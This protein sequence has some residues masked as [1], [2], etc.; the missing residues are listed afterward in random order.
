MV[1]STAVL[2]LAAAGLGRGLATSTPTSAPDNGDLPSSG[3]SYS[4]PGGLQLVIESASQFPLFSSAASQPETAAAGDVDA[5]TPDAADSAAGSPPDEA[6]GA[7][8]TPADEA[9]GASTTPAGAPPDEAD[10]QPARSVRR[11][12]RPTSSGT[13]RRWARRRRCRRH[14]R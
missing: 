4:S 9:D 10:S 5:A 1:G 12:P 14:L 3:T 7:A 6:D 11:W 13:S 8:T 2:T